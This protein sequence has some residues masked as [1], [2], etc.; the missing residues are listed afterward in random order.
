[1]QVIIQAYNNLSYY[2]YTTVKENDGITAFSKVQSGVK[3]KASSSKG[4]PVQG[5]LE[6]TVE[7]EKP[8]IDDRPVVY[9]LSQAVLEFL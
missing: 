7:P 5:F 6:E 4:D 8:R 1:M 9:W 2:F 3:R